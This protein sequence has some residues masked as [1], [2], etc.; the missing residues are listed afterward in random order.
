MGMVGDPGPSGPPGLT[1]ETGPQGRP[2]EVGEEG[3]ILTCS[4]RESLN[5]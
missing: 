5:H 3:M 4:F 1:G 2:G